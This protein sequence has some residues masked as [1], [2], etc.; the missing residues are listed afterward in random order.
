MINKLTL[1]KTLG[2][3]PTSKYCILAEFKC[4]CGKTIVV[5][6]SSVLSGNTRSC[7]CIRAIGGNSYD[8]LYHIYYG[9]K[10]R[11]N[12]TNKLSRAYKYYS[13]RGIKCLWESVQEFDKD[14]RESYENH[15]KVY[16]ERDTTINRIDS[17]G[18]YC[19]DNCRWSTRKEQCQ[20]S[21]DYRKKLLNNKII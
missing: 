14:M 18:H 6:K 12:S 4:D 7:G 9:I 3:D 13:N 19:K 11:V 15:V 8:R 1:I 21:W 10:S 5:R 16:G 2:K 20:Y 17:N